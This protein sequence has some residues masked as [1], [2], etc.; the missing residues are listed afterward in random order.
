MGDLTARAFTEQALL[1]AW[2]EVRDA[3]LAD[4]QSGSEVDQFEAAVARH[5]SRLSAQVADGS[6]QPHP[7]VAVAIAKPSGR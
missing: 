2:D 4:G 1:D 3:A 6:Y 5:V 7:V